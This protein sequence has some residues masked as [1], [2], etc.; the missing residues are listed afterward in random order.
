M[1]VPH[2]CRRSACGCVNRGLPGR[3]ETRFQ[4]AGDPRDASPVP[5]SEVS[6]ERHMAAHSSML[7]WRTYGR[8]GSPA[9]YSP[10]GRNELD[11]PAHV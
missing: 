9:G 10:W 3:G 8:G 7:A 1:D 5:G 4:R 11:T 6:R 2:A